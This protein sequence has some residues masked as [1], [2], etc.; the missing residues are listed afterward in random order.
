MKF[1]R[2]ETEHEV[3]VSVMQ[4]LINDVRKYVFILKATGNH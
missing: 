2:D 1:I 3:L 4:K